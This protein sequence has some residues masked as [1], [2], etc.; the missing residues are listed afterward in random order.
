VRPEDGFKYD[1]FLSYRQQDPDK[2]WVR[3]TLYPR[4]KA[5]GLKAIPLK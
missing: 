4:L 5:E 3:K 2:T 1:V